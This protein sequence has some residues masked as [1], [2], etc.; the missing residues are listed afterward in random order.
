MLRAK[1]EKLMRTALLELTKQDERAIA[2]LKDDDEDFDVEGVNDVD[3][4][5][6]ELNDTAFRLIDM[7]QE[8]RQDQIA[9]RKL[10][11]ERNKQKLALLLA[12]KPIPENLRHLISH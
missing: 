7:V 1:F 8:F 11:I 6:E 4:Q 5:L 2:D 3:E 10:E 9:R 12:G